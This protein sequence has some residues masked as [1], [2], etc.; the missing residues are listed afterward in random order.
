[1]PV[2]RR[3]DMVQH[4]QIDEN[5][6]VIETDHPVAGRLRQARPA[7]EFSDTPIEM[8]RGGPILGEHNDEVLGEAGFEAAEIESLRDAGVLGGQPS[9]EAS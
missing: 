4:P 1:M 5:E 6:I 2:L 3:R 8:R 7:A 9:K